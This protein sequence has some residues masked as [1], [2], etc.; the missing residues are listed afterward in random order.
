MA[1]EFQQKI[2][3]SA[4]S[5]VN[6]SSS[7]HQQ[8]INL[9]VSLSMYAWWRQ[10]SRL[11]TPLIRPA[12]WYLSYLIDARMPR[13][14]MESLRETPVPRWLI[15]HY[16]ETA[17]PRWLMSRVRDTPV[18]RW[19][20]SHYLETTMARWLMPRLFDAPVTRW[21]M[22]HLLEKSVARW[23]MSPLFQRSWHALKFFRDISLHRNTHCSYHDLRYV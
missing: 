12:R 4:V 15:S 11:L 5:N 2:G 17:V 21:L 8:F 23:L 20:L 18:P 9:W 13:W 16:L 7:A 14:L 22:S 10:I 19:L 6:Q 3:A 1:P